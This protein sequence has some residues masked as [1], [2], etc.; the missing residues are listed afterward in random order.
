MEKME[1]VTGINSY[2][3]TIG[4]GIIVMKNEDGSYSGY[5]QTIPSVASTA[6]TEAELKTNLMM[7]L[8]ALIEYYEDRDTRLGMMERIMESKEL[9]FV[10]RPVP[11]GEGDE[12]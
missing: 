2:N 3:D 1:E 6:K 8:K 12:T 10:L 11:T 5:L 7:A 4:M 9:R